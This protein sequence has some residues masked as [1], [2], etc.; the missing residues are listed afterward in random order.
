MSGLHLCTS[1]AAMPSWRLQGEL[2]L[3]SVDILR[4]SFNIYRRGVC[5][6]TK[7]A[8]KRGSYFLSN[9]PVKSYGFLDN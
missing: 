1:S 2:Y 8:E 3:Y 4:N 7:V 6:R 5:F 9:T